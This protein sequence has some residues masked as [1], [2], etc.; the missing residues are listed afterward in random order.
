MPDIETGQRLQS[1]HNRSYEEYNPYY[2]DSDP[3][4]TSGFHRNENYRP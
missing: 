2:T 1:F 3:K 4:T